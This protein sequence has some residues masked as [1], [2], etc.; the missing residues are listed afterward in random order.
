MKRIKLFLGIALIGLL[1]AGIFTACEEDDTTEAT[2]DISESSVPDSVE[3]GVETTLKF[4]VITSEKLGEIELRKGTKTLDTKTEDFSD[5]SSDTYSYT[6]VLA[7]TVEAESTLDM[8]LIVTDSENNQE[9]YDFELYVKAIDTIAVTKYNDKT[10]EVALKDGSAKDLFSVEHGVRYSYDYV[11]SNNIKDSADIVFG[12]EG[13]TKA[14]SFKLL[15]PDYQTDVEI[16]GGGT[17]DNTTNYEV[18]TDSYTYE[19]ITAEDIQNISDL[20]SA[21]VTIVE[22]DIVAFI[23][24]HGHKGFLKVTAISNENEDVGDGDDELTFDMKAVMASELE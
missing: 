15:S 6:G 18:V 14:L 23:T 17:L 13:L 24:E 16:H 20:T 1:G 12:H 8:A 4:S 10:L 9:S 3:A 22:G 21:E 2:I 19:D 7:D 5:K 11:E